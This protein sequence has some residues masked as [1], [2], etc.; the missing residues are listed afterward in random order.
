MQAIIFAL[1]SFLG[2]GI[3]DIPG[4]VASRKLGAFSSILWG[5]SLS[6][7]LLAIYIPFAWPQLSALTP[8]LLVLN[9]ILG[10]IFISSDLL[11]T[12][13]MIIGNPSLVGTICAAFSAVVVI[14]S[15]VFFKESL[16]N[17]QITAIIMIFAGV[18]LSSL[19]VE[20]FYS[21][22]I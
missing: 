10:L 4:T 20:G 2:W 11:F 22:R 13:A 5:I 6:I 8:Q 9:I 3:G 17:I 12:K 14:F 1:I 18:I 15:V 16:T 21:S 19:N 7:L